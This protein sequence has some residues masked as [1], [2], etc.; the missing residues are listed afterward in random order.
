MRLGQVGNQGK[1][2]APHYLLYLQPR[3]VILAKACPMLQSAA[4][5]LGGEQSCG[6]MPDLIRKEACM[7]WSSNSSYSLVVLA[8]IFIHGR[9]DA[10][11]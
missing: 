3:R 6:S 4:L 11:T 8:F 10:Q 5:G 9:I 2:V 1:L 7:R